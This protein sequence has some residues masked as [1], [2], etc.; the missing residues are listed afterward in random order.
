[1][2]VPNSSPGPAA[3]PVSQRAP[4][5]SAAAGPPTD[6]IPFRSRLRGWWAAVANR[7][8]PRA[9]GWL[10]RPGWVRS[11][12]PSL[13]AVAVA[14]GAA[15][16]FDAWLYSCG[17]DRCP[18]ITEIRAFAPAEGGRILD[19]AGDEMGQ[20]RSVRRINVPLES[21]PRYVREAFIATEDR[22]FYEHG[23]VDARGVVRAALTN[24]RSWSVRE[25]FSTITMQAARNTFLAH[26]FPYTERSLRRK[27]I[28]LRV[29]ALM[30][31]ALTK[32]EILE[33]YLNVIYLGNGAYGVEAASRDLFG[34]SVEHLGLAEG[35]VLA[36]LPKGPS[37]Y[38]PR[39]S[40]ERA[41]ARRDLV[42]GLMAS[43]G[44]IDPERAAAAR[45][46]PLRLAPPA[47]R[48][49][50]AVGG[51]ALDAVRSAVDS[52]L[53]GSALRY[54][55]LVVHTTIDQRAQRA[56]ERAVARQAARIQQSTS[57]GADGAGV[58]ARW[59][60]WTRVP[61]R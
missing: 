43:Q 35:A 33:L 53:G 11:A 34:R 14:A 40:M 13:L 55:D 46:Q 42:L 17:F 16:T 28:E 59:W 22:R 47:P 31:Q 45:E 27:L 6:P 18:S 21:V 1:M 7:V 24:I 29:A 37:S 54:G 30:E 58:E 32:D 19:R 15:G 38:T 41:R 36:A 57:R 60:R 23:G 4:A 25:G 5:P 2:V 51:F 56:A 10:P 44:Y 12:W 50:P 52:L 49:D 3:E 48:G 26:R 39:R 61:A 8:N 20:F 9:V